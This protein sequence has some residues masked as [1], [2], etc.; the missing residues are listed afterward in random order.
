MTAAT[1]FLDSLAAEAERAGAAETEWRREAA[2]RTKALAE[3]RTHAF[4]RL[5]LLRPVSAA[6]AGEAQE[7]AAL[8]KGAAAFRLRL[9]WEAPSETQAA[10]VARFRPVLLALFERRAS[11]GQA[12]A[13]AA[14]E[15]WYRTTYGKAFWDLFDQYV[16]E[17]PLVDF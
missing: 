9:G 11:E 8:A 16:P 6:I 13:L 17:T 2:Q 12:A 10:I 3:A 1:S 5:N 15:S 4:R 14:F 7:E